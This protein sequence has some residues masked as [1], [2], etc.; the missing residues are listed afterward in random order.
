MLAERLADDVK[1]IVIVS[2]FS[3]TINEKEVA[4]NFLKLFLKLLDKIKK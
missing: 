3:K 4:R 1:K 2:V